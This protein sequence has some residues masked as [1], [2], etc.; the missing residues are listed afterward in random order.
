MKTKFEVPTIFTLLDLNDHQLVFVELFSRINKYFGKGSSYRFYSMDLRML[1]NQNKN[2][3]GRGLSNVGLET[4]IKP[5]NGLIEGVEIDD[6]TWYLTPN[7]M[8]RSP[9]TEVE[10]TNE[11]AIKAYWYL[12]GRTVGDKFEDENNNTF[13]KYLVAGRHGK[14]YGCCLGLLDYDQKRELN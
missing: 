4:L 3:N 10:I 1:L 2:V 14:V 6:Q 11:A 12:L 9:W 13:D 8:Y 5:F 7:W